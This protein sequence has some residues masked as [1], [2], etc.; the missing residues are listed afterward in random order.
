MSGVLRVGK[1]PR[2]KPP[3]PPRMPKGVKPP[4]PQTPKGLSGKLDEMRA[5]L[6]RPKN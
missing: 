2:I 1:A 4:R 3:Q 5:E 6:G